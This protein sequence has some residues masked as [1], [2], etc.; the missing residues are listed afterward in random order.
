MF[1][2]CTSLA[3]APELPATTLAN[4]CYYGMFRNCTSLENISVGFTSWNGDST[5]GWLD[6]VKSTGTFKCPIQLGTNETITRGTS[7]CP[8]NWNVVMKDYAVV[9]IAEEDGCVIN[10]TSDNDGTT[11]I[12]EL[13]LEYSVDGST[14]TDFDTS[15]SHS[16][17]VTLA[18]I[19]DMVFFRAKNPNTTFCTND[20]A[21]NWFT[22]SKTC[23][24]CGNV[25]AL[26]DGQNRNF[27]TLSAPYALAYLFYE[28]KITD[29]SLL[30]LPAT[31]LTEYCYFSM[32]GECT[33]LTSAP[34]L[35]ATTLANFCYY[36]MFLGCTSL[37][38]AP[39]LP[40]MNLAASCYYSMFYGCVSLSQEINLI[41]P[42]LVDNCYSQMFFGCRALSKLRVEFS[43]W[44]NGSTTNWLNG[45]ASTGEFLCPSILGTDSTITRG[46]SNCPTNW[47]VK[48]PNYLTFTAQ[49]AGATIAMAKSGT[50]P[51]VS[52]KTSTDGGTT[53]QPFVV[54]S[55]IITLSNIGDNVCFAADGSNTGMGSSTNTNNH[56]YFVMNGSIAASGSI[57]S[58]LDGDGLGVDITHNYCFN[59]LFKNCTGL[60]SAPE[61]PATTL[62]NYCYNYMFQGCTAL[63]TPPELPATTLKIGCYRGLFDGCSALSSA[64]ILPANTMISNAYAYMFRNCTS[65][66]SAP[67]LPATT[68]AAGCYR[69]M[70]Y[71]CTAL[72]TPPPTL[73]ATSLTGTYTYQY[74]FYGCS[75]LE[76]APVIGLTTTPSSTQQM[77]YMFQ[78]CS[79]LKEIE[80]HIT[81]WPTTA[82]IMGDWVNG[83]AAAGTFK[84]PAALGTDATITRGTGNCPT[85][86]TV[87]N[88]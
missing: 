49:T 81:S 15:S 38:S 7:Y 83:V 55:T 37:T 67:S 41:A 19:G 69:Y 33:S 86:W 6:G 42:V 57:M 51:E 12:P 68:L 23:T 4:Y 52:L 35:P 39:E 18:N 85:G 5:T 11:P 8:T 45:V 70:F 32:F 27:K 21:W 74:M 87:V 62:A 54:G 59:Y 78:N 16:T 76:K 65:L 20:S 9:F 17:P 34:N 80:I 1:R 56:N 24:V 43:S 31:S 13:S 63:T 72:T 66:I 60:T 58:I 64:P 50:A 71:G 79:K 22:T 3:S 53:W 73:P 84:C 47:T 2:N 36:Q 26:L 14:W 46:V 82:T 44:R 28:C 77:R 29:A 40:A 48:N 10:M 88:T 75:N 30:K 61:M 25:M